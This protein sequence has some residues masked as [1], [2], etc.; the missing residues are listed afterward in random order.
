[1]GQ[2]DYSSEIS[3]ASSLIAKATLSYIVKKIPLLGLPVI[4]PFFGWALGLVL[5]IALTQTVI[6]VQILSHYFNTKNQSKKFVEKKNALQEALKK[7]DKN[8]IK[9]KELEFDDAFYDLIGM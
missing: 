7:G 2:A 4:N 6:G 3:T 8:E 9:K 1:M 5:D